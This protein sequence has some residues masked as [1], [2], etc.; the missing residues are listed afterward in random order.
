MRKEVNSTL[1]KLQSRE[2]EN[3]ISAAAIAQSF[4]R[5]CLLNGPMS[6]SQ[7]GR[8]VEKAQTFGYY[9]ISDIRHG[10]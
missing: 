9:R 10:L 5:A 3:P 6:V 2:P 8:L 7:F 1:S 4:S